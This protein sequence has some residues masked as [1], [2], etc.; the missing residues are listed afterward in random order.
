MFYCFWFFRVRILSGESF[1]RFHSQMVSFHMMLWWWRNQSSFWTKLSSGWSW[2]MITTFWR[3]WVAASKRFSGIS[4]WASYHLSTTERVRWMKLR[5]RRVI[6]SSLLWVSAM[7]LRVLNPISIEST[8]QI[9][10]LIKVDWSR[11]WWSPIIPSTDLN[12][13]ISLAFAIRSD[14]FSLISLFMFGFFRSRHLY[15]SC[16]SLSLWSLTVSNCFV[17]SS[18]VSLSLSFKSPLFVPN[19][20]VS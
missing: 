10:V 1:G 17:L 9:V 2:A 18:H 4:L 15:L 3:A 20:T 8:H 16:N 13:V 6:V 5:S 19:N 11:W 12:I 14:V 7:L